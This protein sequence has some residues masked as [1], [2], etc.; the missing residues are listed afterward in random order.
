MAL[1]TS[2]RQARYRQRLKDAALG[3]TP[4]MIVAETRRLYEDD[5]SG[6]G[7]STWE[8]WLSDRAPKRNA[9]RDLVRCLGEVSA[10]DPDATPQLLRVA[11][12][13]RSVFS[14]PAP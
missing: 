1:T 13:V 6:D 12:V 8:E 10:D 2:E 5:P 11:A 7:S 4:A 14:P 3:V 9:W